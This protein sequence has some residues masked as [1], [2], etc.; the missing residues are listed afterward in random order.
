MSW[1]TFGETREVGRSS[2]SGDTSEPRNEFSANSPDLEW[3]WN[4]MRPNDLGNFS[5]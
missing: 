2:P 5:L 3:Y 1:K 4:M